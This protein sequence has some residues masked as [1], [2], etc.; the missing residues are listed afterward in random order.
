LWGGGKEFFKRFWRCALVIKGYCAI[1]KEAISGYSNQEIV[2]AD[3]F[4]QLGNWRKL[5]VELI[6]RREL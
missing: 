1:K 2:L 3:M 6:G 5:G 4:K